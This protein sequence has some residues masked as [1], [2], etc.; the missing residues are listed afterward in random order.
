M[1]AGAGTS[2]HFE[3]CSDVEVSELILGQS[4]FTFEQDGKFYSIQTYYHNE[5]AAADV[6]EIL[7]N[8]TAQ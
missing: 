4:E 7:A 3:L 8:M 5:T 2:P 1:Q 6:D